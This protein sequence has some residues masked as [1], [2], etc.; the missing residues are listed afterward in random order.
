MR[1]E[2]RNPKQKKLHTFSPNN[3]D[4]VVALVEALAS[5]HTGF[6]VSYKNIQFLRIVESVI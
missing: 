2:S 4:F 6:V 1:T 5:F 3:T